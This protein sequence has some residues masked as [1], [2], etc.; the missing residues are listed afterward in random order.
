MTARQRPGSLFLQGEVVH[1]QEQAYLLSVAHRA[2]EL[3][4][5]LKHDGVPSRVA[6]RIVENYCMVLF[7]PDEDA[8]EGI[9]A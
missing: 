2:G 9:G 5:A 1:E 3:Y 7:M 4:A 6:V 8:G